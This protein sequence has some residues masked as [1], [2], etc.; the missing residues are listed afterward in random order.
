MLRS[1][2]HDMG[3][4]AQFSPQ[5]IFPN[6]NPVFQSMYNMYSWCAPAAFF[7]IGTNYRPLSHFYQL[8]LIK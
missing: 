4:T 2:L 6:E 5:V 1:L 8:L 3:F 7:C